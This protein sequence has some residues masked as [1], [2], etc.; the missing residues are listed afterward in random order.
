MAQTEI[1]SVISGPTELFI[2]LGFDV[3]HNE[4]CKGWRWHLYLQDA[5]RRA[6]AM[7]KEALRLIAQDRAEREARQAAQT[8]AT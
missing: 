7:R 1:L 4:H 5:K 3:Q 2:G 8:S 6:A